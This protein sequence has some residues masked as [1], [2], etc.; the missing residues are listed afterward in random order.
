MRESKSSLFLDRYFSITNKRRSL[1]DNSSNTRKHKKSNNKITR[2]AMNPLNHDCDIKNIKN[3]KNG[4][5]KK[6]FP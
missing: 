2:I 5:T 6:Y 4:N 1:N 3:Q